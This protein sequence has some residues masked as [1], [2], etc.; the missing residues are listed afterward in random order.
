MSV[1]Q[2]YLING[3]I[4]LTRLENDIVSKFRIETTPAGDTLLSE[5]NLS[6]E[7]PAVVQDP[8]AQRIYYFSGDFANA[9]Y[10]NLDIQI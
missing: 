8:L 3:L 10:S 9:R 5:N 6:A 7:F 2:L 1:P 4:L